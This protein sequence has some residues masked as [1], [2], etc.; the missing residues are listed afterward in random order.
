MPHT[1]SERLVPDGACVTRIDLEALLLV[2]VAPTGA[3]VDTSARYVV[4][5]GD[6]LSHADRV[7]V[8]QHDDTEAESNA[9]GERCE[10]ADDYLGRGRAGERREEVVLDEPDVVEPDA[11]G[12]DALL[13]G[14][15]DKRLLVH[16]P[17]GRGPLHLID[18]PKIHPVHPSHKLV[19]ILRVGEG[20]VNCDG[21]RGWRVIASNRVRCSSAPVGGMNRGME[22]LR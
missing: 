5:H 20:G 2:G 16:N 19:R 14:L 18:D 12:Q 8:G 22:T 6:F 10:G 17:V 15:F 1:T 7:L 9:L 21:W 13:D 3:E 11:V 4:G